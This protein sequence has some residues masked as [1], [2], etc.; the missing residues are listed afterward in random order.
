MHEAPCL[1]TSV[2]FQSLLFAG[3]TNMLERKGRGG[4]ERE[5][6]TERGR[7]G[8]REERGDYFMM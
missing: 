4:R 2:G 5:R 8:E 6:K 3:T 1:H 7:D